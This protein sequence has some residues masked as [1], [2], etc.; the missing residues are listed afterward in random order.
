MR[1]GCCT[2]P[3]WPALPLPLKVAAPA[4]RMLLPECSALQ[5]TGEPAAVCCRSRDSELV[6]LRY[7]TILQC[8]VAV[9]PI[10]ARGNKP[11]RLRGEFCFCEKRGVITGHT[12]V[13][14]QVECVAAHGAEAAAVIMQSISSPAPSPAVIAAAATLKARG[15]STGGPCVCTHCVCPLLTLSTAILTNNWHGCF[16]FSGISQHFDVIIEFVHHSQITFFL[17]LKPLH[18]LQNRRSQA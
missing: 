15:F 1:A 14:A 8:N 3:Q 13:C 16:D 9:G 2:P 11:E 4:S 17:P 6:R 7:L 10:G 18:V 5:H 12:A